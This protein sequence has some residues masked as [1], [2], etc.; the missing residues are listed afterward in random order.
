M[1]IFL[2]HLENWIS[3]YEKAIKFRPEELRYIDLDLSYRQTK[4]FELQIHIWSK[5]STKTLILV[6]IE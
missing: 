5:V 1:T 4:F 6:E 3:N 2:N